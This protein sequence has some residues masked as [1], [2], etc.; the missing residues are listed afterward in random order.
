MN[1]SKI[2]QEHKIYSIICLI[3]IVAI[4]KCLCLGYHNRLNIMDPDTGRV[5][6]KVDMVY[7]YAALIGCILLLL[8]V[9]QMTGPKE[10]FEEI[11][12]N[13]YIR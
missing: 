9:V 12:L 10:S 5:E 11:L 2:I 3:L 1:A 8:C 13:D 4:S 7:V 6:N